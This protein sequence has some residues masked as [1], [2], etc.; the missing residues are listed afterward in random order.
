MLKPYL[1]LIFS[2]LCSLCLCGSSFAAPD[3]EV[4]KPYHLRV[5]L[6]VA[7]NRLLTPVFKEQLRRELRDSLQAS[8]G[9]LGKV[10]VVDKHPLLQEIDTKGM[11]PALEG[12]K[13]VSDIK[14]H[15]VLIDFV[16]GQYVIQTG[17]HDGST[18]LISPVRR[19]QTV[20]RQFVAREATL[21]I[22]RDFGLVGTVEPKGKNEVTVTLKGSGLGVA[23]ERWVK[24]DEV[25]ALAQIV[26]GR[27][28]KQSF[29]V[30]WA[31]VQVLDEPKGGVC[32]CRLFHRYANPLTTSANVLGYR[33]LKLGTT[34]APLHL[35]LIDDK[36][37]APL[38][39]LQVQVSAYGFPMGDKFQQC[40]TRPD[41]L[42]PD[43]G[44]EHAYQHA[45]FFRVLIGTAPVTSTIP[46][47]ILGDRVIV[48]RVTVDAKLEALGQLDLR[49]KRWVDRLNENLLVQAE[50]SKRLSDLIGKSL[51]EQALVQAENGLKAL[52]ADLIELN[53]EAVALHTAVKALPAGVTLQLA[54]GQQRF[55]EIKAWEQK[56]QAAVKNLQDVIKE[57]DNQKRK[58]A[59]ALVAQAKALEDQA[60]YAQAIEQYE[61][62]LELAGDQMD[63]VKRLKEL[64]EAWEPKNKAHSQARAF[65]YE[66]WPKLDTVK[67]V[68]DNLEKARQAFQ[69]CRDAGD[70]L[71]PGKLLLVSIAHTRLL[72]K[73]LEALKPQDGEDARE[74]IKSI[75]EVAGS[76][77][78]LLKEVGDYIAENPPAK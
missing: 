62:A 77:E 10:E 76:L 43:A 15:F 19:V 49:K 66:T 78:K 41:G 1:P 29:R 20:D 31:L 26:Q 67:K 12:W 21:L 74:K 5:V 7:S 60:E 16:N 2:S 44:L 4:N 52:K 53:G 71:S 57:K 39:G 69:T 8:L 13:Q 9:A 70:K 24:K 22:D 75:E 59:K 33:C 72:E 18:G 56:L 37:L 50:L 47:E 46:V 65:I 32:R 42:L 35:R 54:E 6:H 27:E 25:F 38:G 11:A 73:E 28:G 45:A 58:E 36:T 14:T 55:E 17:Q 40:T 30:P 68:K 3:A 34:R 61:K 64:K 51:N 48:C 23:L 63:L